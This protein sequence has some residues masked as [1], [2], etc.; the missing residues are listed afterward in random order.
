MINLRDKKILRAFGTYV[1]E[2]R[3]KAGLT[4]KQLANNMDVEISQISRIETGKINPSL[5]TI[6]K[7]AN[8]LEIKPSKLMD[9]EG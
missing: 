8:T 5:C 7:L 6:V 4:Q 1:R 2:L 9:F 3:E